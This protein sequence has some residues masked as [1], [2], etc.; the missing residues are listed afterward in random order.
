[1]YFDCYFQKNCFQYYFR[2]LILPMSSHNDQ[3]ML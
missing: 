2:H 3:I 1:L